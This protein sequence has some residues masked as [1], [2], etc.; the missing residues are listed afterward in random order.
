MS[1]WFLLLSSCMCC[2]VV[3]HHYAI[4]F[5]SFSRFFLLDTLDRMIH[6]EGTLRLTLGF[7]EEE[8]DRVGE[9]LCITGH[10]T[11]GLKATHPPLTKMMDQQNHFLPGSNGRSVECMHRAG[12]FRSYM[13]GNY[14]KATHWI[15]A[16]NPFIM[17]NNV[18][19]SV[20]CFSATLS[21][22]WFTQFAILYYQGPCIGNRLS[23]DSETEC[24]CLEKTL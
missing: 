1:V 17:Y 14:C 20:M 7:R 8:D 15:V 13:S 16:L 4:H 6:L 2:C 11:S 19:Y 24:R 12:G 21:G 5:T 9:F 22:T 23:F 18:I 3:L 10:Y